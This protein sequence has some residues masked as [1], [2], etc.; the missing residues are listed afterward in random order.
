MTAIFQY[1]LAVSIPLFILW[2]I[3]RWSLASEKQFA[4]NRIVLLSIYAISLTL[5]PITTWIQSIASI[6]AVHHGLTIDIHGTPTILHHASTVAAIWAVGAGIAL[7]ASVIEF[8]RIHAVIRRSHRIDTNGTIVYVSPDKLLSP[9]SFGSIIVMNQEDYSE[10][11]DTILCHETGHIRH[12]HSIDMVI[13]QCV[14]ILCWYNPAAWL[15]RSELKSVHEYQADMFT[16]TCGCNPR[17][18]QLFLIRKAVGP[19]F[20]TIANNLNHR[21]LRQRISMMN[22]NPDTGLWHRMRYTLPLAGIIAGAAILAIPAVKAAI[23]PVTVIP[24]GQAPSAVL[25]E[26]DVYVDGVEIPKEHLNDMP[27]DEIKSISID[28]NTNRI[29]VK[30]KEQH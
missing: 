30:T 23:T 3:Y 8:I 25:E 24:E 11:R 18:Y 22:R 10:C 15:M 12:H 27:S 2:V 5:F 6:A 9:F 1:T 7:I 28:R 14:A 16:L 17:D 26:I 21:K 29:D 4:A 19:K 20:P 13:A